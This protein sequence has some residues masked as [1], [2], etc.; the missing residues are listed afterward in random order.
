[1]GTTEGD[2]AESLG[3]R[4]ARLRRAK[5]W[6]QKELAD[7]VGAKPTQISKYERGN[8]LPR[9]D[10]LPKLGEVL[11]VSLDYLMTGRSGGE[12]RRDVRLRERVEAL[13]TLPETQR[14]NLVAFLDALL[15]AHQLLRRYQ[16]LLHQH[17]RGA[18]HPERP[19]KGPAK[20]RV[21]KGG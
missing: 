5:G 15:A 20:E 16:E 9:P 8:Y 13:E 2:S 21:R 11:G 3:G 7:R 4:I 6:N 12:P 19:G 1:M 17:G 10:L 14:S 18:L